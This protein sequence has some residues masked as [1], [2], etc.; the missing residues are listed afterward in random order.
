M[1]EHKQHVCSQKQKKTI[2]NVTSTNIS[3]SPIIIVKITT[4][5]TASKIL[6]CRHTQ[7]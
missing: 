3:D 7:K 2:N 5:I 1:Q 4:T 6:I